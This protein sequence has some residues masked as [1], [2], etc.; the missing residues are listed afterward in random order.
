MPVSHRLLG[1]EPWLAVRKAQQYPESHQLRIKE[2]GGSVR[3]CNYS[4]ERLMC[5]ESM[6]TMRKHFKDNGAAEAIVQQD[7][8]GLGQR[9]DQGPPNL[10]HLES[11]INISQSQRWCSAAATFEP[12]GGGHVRRESP[13]HTVIEKKK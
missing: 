9:F 13:C 10:L 3:A 7:T 2:V 8:P 4:M 5:N 1:W 12:S 11:T 6:S